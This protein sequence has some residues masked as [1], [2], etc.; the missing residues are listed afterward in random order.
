MIK[1]ISLFCAVSL[2]LASQIG[3]GCG[4]KPESAAPGYGKL[5]VAVNQ[6]N[7]SSFDPAAKPIKV[8]LKGDT[9]SVA[10]SRL[11]YIARYSPAFDKLDSIDLTDPEPISPTSYAYSDSGLL[12]TDHARGL[13]IIYD[14]AGRVVTSFGTLPD[15]TTPLM[16]F[17]ITYF[18]GV[19]YIGDVGQKKVL[20]VSLAEAEGITEVGELI[21][22]I[23]T[24]TAHLIGFPL[25]LKVTPDG[26]L[27]VGDA[28]DGRVKVYTCDGRYI[29]NFD[30]PPTQNTPAPQDFAFDDVIDPTVQDSS[31][32]D[33]S[34]IRRQGRIHVP[35]AA[36]GKVHMFSPL[37]KYIASYPADSS[38]VRPTGVAID[39]IRNRIYVAD[40][41]AGR[42]VVFGYEDLD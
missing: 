42:I 37:G 32:F 28:A 8:R 15:G 12:V 5:P 30:S 20:A 17:S 19:A 23:P 1:R 13:V 29:Y 41:E 33:P 26:R 24:D 40:P 3:P 14:R 38:L 9:L 7:C 35:D 21:L 27:L 39:R 4:E 11:P 22:T 6:F 18:G 2:W 10:F 34:G 25:S 31:S 16:P 36:N